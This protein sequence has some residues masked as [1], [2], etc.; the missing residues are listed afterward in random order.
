MLVN[1]PDSPTGRVPL[2]AQVVAEVGVDLYNMHYR[3]D[4]GAEM[5]KLS[6]AKATAIDTTRGEGIEDPRFQAAR[7]EIAPEIFAVRRGRQTG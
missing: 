4:A 2:F 6:A 3:D 7:R 1:A 5:S